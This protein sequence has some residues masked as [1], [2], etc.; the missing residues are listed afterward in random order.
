MERF[1]CEPVL[2]RVL[3]ASFVMRSSVRTHEPLETKMLGEPWHHEPV[4]YLEGAVEEEPST[5]V[6]GAQSVMR[7][8]PTPGVLSTRKYART[9][10]PGS[11]AR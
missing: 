2:Y 1:A 3:L 6:P 7:S 10:W 5:G 9:R 4:P 11:R 8:P